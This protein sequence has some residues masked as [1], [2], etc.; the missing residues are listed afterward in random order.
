LESY[1]GGPRGT[2]GTQYLGAFSLTV[3]ANSAWLITGSFKT[4]C[5][6]RNVSVARKATINNKIQICLVL[7]STLL[8]SWHN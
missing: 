6:G 8:K 3:M 7:Q 2:M 1:T 4:K 5:C